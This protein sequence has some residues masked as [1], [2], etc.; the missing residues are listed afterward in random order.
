MKVDDPQL[1]AYVDGGLRP[2]ERAA[3]EA[4]LRTS[5]EMRQKIALLRASRVDF[6]KAFAH[7]GMPPVP[8]SLRLKI[9]DM[10]RVLQTRQVCEKPDPGQI[11]TFQQEHRRKSPGVPLWLTAACVACAFVCGQFTHINFLAGEAPAT[12][13]SDGRQTTSNADASSWVAAAVGYQKLFARETVAYTSTDRSAASK[14]VRDIRNDDRLQIR[15]PDLR[16]AGLT[17]KAVQRLR[18]DNQ[19]LV[20]IIYLPRSGPPIALCVMKDPRR[21]E[22]VATRTVDAMKVAL[23]RQAEISYA[24]IGDPKGPDLGELGKRISNIDVAPLFT[25]TELTDVPPGM[26]PWAA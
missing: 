22:R 20:H 18:F 19:P 6:R 16:S 3:V 5:A 1:L 9:D 12:R 4:Q 23:W 7:Q 10:S 13:A 17:F 8:E 15:V 25:D 14:I 2:D 21:D 11:W 26:A 24:L